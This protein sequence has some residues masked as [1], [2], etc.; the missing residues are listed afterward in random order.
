MPPRA[1][2]S[3]VNSAISSASEFPRPPPVAQQK[4]QSHAR[5]KLGRV[6]K[7]AVVGIE[8]RTKVSKSAIQEIAGQIVPVVAHARQ[9]SQM[10]HNLRGL[11]CDITSPVAV[12]GC[13]SLQHVR[14][15]GASVAV[16]GWEIG[17]AIEGLEIGE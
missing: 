16:I 2:F 5:W 11:L 15:S 7:T 3:S 8:R 6:P 13:D 17:A 4:R 9:L 10:I 14:K 12:S 1:I